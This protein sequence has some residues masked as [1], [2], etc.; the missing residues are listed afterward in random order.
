MPVADSHALSQGSTMSSSSTTA[1][2]STTSGDDS[3]HVDF[4]S[5]ASVHLIDRTLP[6][7]THL[8]EQASDDASNGLSSVED[9]SCPW[10][11]E[12]WAAGA[13]A[14]EEGDR[15]A[16]V[17]GVDYGTSNSC[18]AVWAVDKRRAKVIKVSGDM[19][20][21]AEGAPLLPSAVSFASVPPAVGACVSRGDAGAVFHA[22][23]LIGRAWDDPAVADEAAYCPHELVPVADAS[24]TQRPSY[25]LRSGGGGGGGG[26]F[27][28]PDDAARTVLATLAAAARTFVRRH[29]AP[30]LARDAPLDAVLTVPAYFGGAQVCE[31]V[32]VYV[33][34]C[35]WFWWYVWV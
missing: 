26:A 15:P 32:R 33:G 19:S 24:G 22:K 3:P 27:V 6:S 18:V 8:S 10:T 9:A 16:V 28:T 23:R 7:E 31:C 25:R 11:V 21:G 34:V 12:P 20:A 30:G 2:S 29:G 17:V 1:S 5:T 35:V 13:A 4:R 14:G